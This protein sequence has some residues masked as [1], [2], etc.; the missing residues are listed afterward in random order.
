[1]IDRL[2]R[3]LSPTP[4]H[5][6]RVIVLVDRPAVRVVVSAP[7]VQ[8]LPQEACCYCG[9]TDPAQLVYATSRRPFCAFTAGCMD[10]MRDQLVPGRW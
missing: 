8:P 2:V 9:E 6:R 3:M 5:R 4:L 1:M 7:P 10:R